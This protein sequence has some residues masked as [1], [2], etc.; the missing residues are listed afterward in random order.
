MVD[1]VK[2]NFRQMPKD[3]KIYTQKDSPYFTKESR[4]ELNSKW[5]RHR[6]PSRP[7]YIVNDKPDY[8]SEDISKIS[9]DSSFMEKQIKIAVADTKL[10]LSM[11]DQVTECMK[12][13]D[14]KKCVEMFKKIANTVHRAS[15]PYIDFLIRKYTKKLME[16]DHGNQSW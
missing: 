4:E 16:I 5:T 11:A 13:T 1:D 2:D 9:H 8:L 15:K 14:L 10:Q 6:Y 3:V 7:N 12:E